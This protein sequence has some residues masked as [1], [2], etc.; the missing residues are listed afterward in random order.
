MDLSKVLIMGIASSCVCLGEFLPCPLPLS[1]W[2]RAVV[3]DMQK[4]KVTA[5]KITEIKKVCAGEKKQE[6][7]FRLK[8]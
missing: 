8:L 2:H 1:Y 4:H 5:C 3:L 7:N 6:S